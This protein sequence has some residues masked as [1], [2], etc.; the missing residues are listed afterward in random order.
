MATKVLDPINIAVIAPTGAGKTA[1]ISTVCDYIKA[2]SNKSKGYTLEI[3]NSAAM[4]LNNF[5]KNLSAQLAGKNLG[6]KS[7]LIQPTNTCTDYMFSMNFEDKTSGLSIKQPFKILDIPGA[8]VNNPLMYENDSEYQRFIN[9]LDTSRILW[10]PIDTPVLMEANTDKKKSQSDLI[11]CTTSLEDFAREWAQYAEGND[12]LDFCN[13]VLVKCETYFSQDVNNRYKGC[14]ARFDEAYGSIVETMKQENH[15]DKF[16]CV[17]VETIGPI[18]VKNAKF[19]DD[20]CEVEYTFE[21]SRQKIAGA[22]C[23]L[24]DALAVAKDNVSAEIDIEKANKTADRVEFSQKLE[25]IIAEQ[26]EKINGMTSRRANLQEQYAKLAAAESRLANAGFWDS[27]FDIFGLGSLPEV[28]AK[29]RNLNAHIM[30]LNSEMAAEQ[31]KLDELTQKKESTQQDIH[32]VDTKISA[33]DTMKE[34]FN[35]LAGGNSESKYYR[36]L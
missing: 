29:I 34:W 36:S 27:L 17:A 9:H 10:I 1:L 24:R 26:R 12:R 16:A 5:K 19:K 33:L 7:Q 15:E 23:L 35:N 18:K 32:D 8:F 14:K 25:R 28:R 4:E 20:S 3:E 6:F 30:S 31:D 2:N 21:G 22:D 11:R 13:F